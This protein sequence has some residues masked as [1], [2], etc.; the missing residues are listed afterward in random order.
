[1]ILYSNILKLLHKILFYITNVKIGLLANPIH[2]SVD[3][4]V[5]LQIGFRE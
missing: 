1:M 5:F 3:G 4:D 2:S